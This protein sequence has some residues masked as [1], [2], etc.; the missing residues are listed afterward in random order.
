MRTTKYVNRRTL[1]WFRGGLEQPGTML[2]VETGNHELLETDN[3]YH[4]VLQGPGELQ[5]RQGLAIKLHDRLPGGMSHI[6]GLECSSKSPMISNTDPSGHRVAIEVGKNKACYR[7]ISVLL[8]IH[9]ST[10]RSLHRTR[11]L[12]F[13]LCGIG[14]PELQTPPDAIDA[15][16]QSVRVFMAAKLIPGSHELLF[17][18]VA[19]ILEVLQPLFQ[20]L[21]R[22]AL[23]NIVSVI[24]LR[25]SGL[26]TCDI[27]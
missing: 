22:G 6:L 13:P 4:V 12:P 10:L 25:A 14:F 5:R 7:R 3:T 2:I 11:G 9:K 19:Q 23:C 8:S 16:S 18:N 1:D 26:V 17:H 24:V 27:P 21:D 15:A 20:C